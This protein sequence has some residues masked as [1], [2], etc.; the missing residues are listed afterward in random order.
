MKLK[1][2]FRVYHKTDFHWTD[3]AGAYVA[4]ALVDKLGNLT[5]I[6]DLWDLPIKIR[7]EKISYG[8]ENHALALL[9]PLQEDALFL[10]TERS[11][12]GEYLH[13]QE[14]NEWTFHAKAGPQPRLLHSTV[15]FG[16]SFADAFT[17]AGLT[18]YFSEFHKFYNWDFPKMFSKIPDGTRYLVLQHI[19]TFLLPLLNP[20]FWPEEAKSK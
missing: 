17:R 4:K 7:T 13:T 15:M 3:P 1:G 10:E 11:G 20:T 14:D 6:G 19:E 12:V 16:D 2:S 18:V 5:G 9:W 8:G